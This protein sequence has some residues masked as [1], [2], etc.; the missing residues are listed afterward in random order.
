MDFIMGAVAMFGVL[1]IFFLCIE[2]PVKSRDFLV[3]YK[4]EH[5]GGSANGNEIVSTLDNKY[6][7]SNEFYE[8]ISN[9]EDLPFSKEEIVITNII[10]LTDQELIDWQQ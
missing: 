4:A 3:F 2:P 10:E 5:E 8:Y 9:S 1:M 7:N 6:I